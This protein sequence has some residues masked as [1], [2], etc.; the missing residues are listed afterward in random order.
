MVG[1]ILVL[2]CFACQIV[3]LVRIV[4]DWVLAMT[5]GRGTPW[6]AVPYGIA[7]DLTEPVLRPIRRHLPMLRVGAAALDLSPLLV[8]LVLIVL[9]TIASQLSF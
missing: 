1:R 9:Q 8:F 7:Y 3:L 6:M 4:L 2:I 5:R